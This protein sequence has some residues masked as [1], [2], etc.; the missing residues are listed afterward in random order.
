MT[1][2]AKKSVKKPKQ[3]SIDTP[4]PGMT[5]VPIPEFR[6]WDPDQENPRHQIRG[7]I[8]EHRT[9]NT[10]F[11]ARR[12]TSI[13]TTCAGEDCEGQWEQ[14]TVIDVWNS[15]GLMQL[16]TIQPGTE[17]L[18]IPNGFQDSGKGSPMKAFRVYR[19]G[20]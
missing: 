3:T 16:K 14:G 6:T 9:V 5:E 12:A 15:A 19:A 17:I 2:T 10:T 11:G 4:P 7:D 8:T 1:K 20:K 18:I 13:I